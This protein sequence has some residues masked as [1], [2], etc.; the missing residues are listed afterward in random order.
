[1]L[2]TCSISF[3]LPDDK[4]IRFLDRLKLVF[5]LV[6]SVATTRT[7]ERKHFDLHGLRWG[8]PADAIYASLSLPT[9]HERALGIVPDYVLS[10]AMAPQNVTTKL[11][12][13]SKYVLG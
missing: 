6:V 11:I 13:G 4:T 1:M 10:P 8:D 3:E 2:R 5:R 7:L 9:Y 12:E